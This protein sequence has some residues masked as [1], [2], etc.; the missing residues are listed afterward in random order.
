MS[1][2][3]EDTL[4]NQSKESRPFFVCLL[5]AKSRVLQ[6]CLVRHLFHKTPL[7]EIK[8]LNC[9]TQLQTVVF[10]FFVWENIPQPSNLNMVF[11]FHWPPG[12]Q[13]YP[14]RYLCFPG[15]DWRAILSLFQR[16]IIRPLL[17][18]LPWQCEP[19]QRCLPPSGASG[20]FRLLP[21]WWEAT[22]RT[23]VKIFSQ[24]V[25]HGQH[26][27]FCASQEFSCLLDTWRCVQDHDGFSFV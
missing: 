7:L 6:S 20:V 1:S 21:H 17:S 9:H 5:F 27:W 18:C 14:Q 19:C 11:K 22:E 12:K 2:C 4:S 24:A 23:K 16:N 8:A 13:C 26:L 3:R 10:W 15:A 25:L